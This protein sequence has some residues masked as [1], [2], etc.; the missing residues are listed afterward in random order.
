MAVGGEHHDVEVCY[1]FLVDPERGELTTLV[2]AQDLT[3]T[4]ASA[5]KRVVE[6]LAN[7]VDDCPL[8][9]KAKRLLGALP[10]SWSFAMTELPPGRRLELAERTARLDR[11]GRSEADR[12]ARLERAL[13]RPRR[14]EGMSAG[15]LRTLLL[16]LTPQPPD[17]ILGD[18]GEL[19]PQDRGTLE[20]GPG[21]DEGGVHFHEQ[22]PFRAFQPVDPR[23]ADPPSIHL[24]RFDT[25]RTQGL[26]VIGERPRGVEG[27][28]GPG[29]D[30]Q[31]L[32]RPRRHDLR[33]R[34]DLDPVEQ[35][36]VDVGVPSRELS[37]GKVSTCLGVSILRGSAACPRIPCSRRRRA[38]RWPG[39]DSHRVDFLE[40]PADDEP[41]VDPPYGA[42]IRPGVVHLEDENGAV[43]ES[44]SRSARARSDPATPR[45]AVCWASA[46]CPS[47]NWGAGS[48]TATPPRSN[49]SR[50]IAAKTG[51]FAWSGP[52][53]AASVAKNVRKAILR[54]SIGPIVSID[55]TVPASSAHFGR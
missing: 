38:G 34:P 23:V 18:R 1:G 28:I 31:R 9:V 12:P 33:G 19:R 36:G 27:P 51:L 44:R 11:L 39:L 26:P 7:L 54:V 37:A 35:P 17:L 13:A 29:R 22:G 2:W 3:E 43:T 49:P 47:F 14:P 15:R 8:D 24:I 50:T 53:S 21:L 5:V 48:R 10:V 4:D 52:R 42:L 32:G 45:S 55:A 40:A 25:A 20:P 41:E 46:S 30:H 16:E 6:L